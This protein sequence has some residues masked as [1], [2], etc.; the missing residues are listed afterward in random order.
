MLFYTVPFGLMADDGD[1]FGKSERYEIQLAI[2]YNYEPGRRAPYCSNPSNPAYYD[3]GDREEIEV[4]CVQVAQVTNCE[5]ERVTWCFKEFRDY[6]GGCKFRDCKHGSDPG[7]LIREAVEQ[8]KI[9]AERYHNYHRILE[10]MQDARNM[11][12]VS[13]E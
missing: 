4:T 3:A 7:C 11:R 2:D 5:N 10:S 8:G 1:D 9:S 13:R 6:L 12:H